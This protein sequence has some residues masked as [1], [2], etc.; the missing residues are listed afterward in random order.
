MN[1]HNHCTYTDWKRNRWGFDWR[2][3]CPEPV[4]ICEVGV[5]PLSLSMLPYFSD[6]E[7]MA[8]AFEPNP[9]MAN[10]AREA[11]PWVELV[12]KAVWSKSG[13]HVTLQLNNGSSGIIG[14]WSPTPGGNGTVQVETVRFGEAVLHTKFD[15]LNI[16]CEG[17]EHYVL[18]D[19][20]QFELPLPRFIGIELWPQ[21]PKA[22]YCEDW[23]LRHGYRP[24]FATGPNSE[25]SIWKK[26]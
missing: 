2:V 21:Y 11:L 20:E 8:F 15:I 16:D 18:E 22:A 17:S 6:L 7:P 4:Y 9:V 19:I 13:D 24:I 14:Q 12:E 1:I 10:A 5:G 26:S 23:L 3:I 25:T